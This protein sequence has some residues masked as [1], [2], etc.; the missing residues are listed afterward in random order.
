MKHQMIWRVWY[1]K[2]YRSRKC[3][4][5]DVASDDKEGA[6]LKAEIQLPE[7]SVILNAIFNRFKKTD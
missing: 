7:G 5:I 1:H 3:Y 6:K 4:F 2:T